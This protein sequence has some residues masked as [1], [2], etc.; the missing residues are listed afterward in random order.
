MFPV[1]PDKIKIILYTNVL[2]QSRWKNLSHNGYLR[3]IIEYKYDLPANGFQLIN[4]YE[5]INRGSDRAMNGQK[6]NS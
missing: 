6:N 5:L 4:Q 1:Q 3:P 2:V